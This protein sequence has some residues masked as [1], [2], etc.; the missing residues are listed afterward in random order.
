MLKPHACPLNALVNYDYHTLVNTTM[1]VMCSW[2]K[3][4]T[5]D[6]TDEAISDNEEALNNRPRTWVECTI[7]E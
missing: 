4:M 5:D 1:I 2:R 6:T 7:K 3:T